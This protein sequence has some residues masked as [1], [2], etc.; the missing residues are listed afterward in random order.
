M[1]GHRA[2]PYILLAPCY[3]NP[4]TRRRYHKTIEAS[5]DFESNEYRELLEHTE[6]AALRALHPS[7]TAHFWGAIATHNN[8]MDR[9][10]TGD[11]V[12]F[13]GEN[14]VKVAGEIGHLFRNQAMADL[15]WDQFDSGR[16]FV[17]VYSVRNIQVIER[18]RREVW[19]RLG[20]D[21]GDNVAGQRLVIGDR[22]PR[23]LSELRVVP[24]SDEARI[25]AQLEAVDRAL[26]TGS[27]VIPVETFH[28]DVVSLHITERTAQHER[29][30]SQLLSRY[31]QF[32]P[33]VTFTSFRTHNG[34]RAD[35]YRVE[36]GEVEILEAK[37]LANHEKVREAA[38]QLLDYSAESPQPVTRLSALFPLRPDQYGV[39]YLH[40]LGIDCVYRSDSGTFV[41]EEAPE[42]RRSYMH[43]VWRGG[44]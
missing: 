28:T 32:H 21:E 5:I 31:Q 14:K 30:E 39:D 12:V 17:N 1:G 4:K 13:T 38:G 26:A 11:I 36:E 8:M 9:L 20:F 35:L 29:V 25:G 27:Q 24:S 34:K 7:G 22:V 18:S 43:V 6:L 23:M 19:R 37:S 15:M 41:R 42:D 3:G 16:S 44:S 10:R 2:E 40:R 33:D